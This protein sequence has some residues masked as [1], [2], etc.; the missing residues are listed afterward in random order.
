LISPE[1][2]K[3]AYAGSLATLS[4]YASAHY[5]TYSILNDKNEIIA[6]VISGVEQAPA[7]DHNNA[8]DADNFASCLTKFLDSS[9][10][11]SAKE[12]VASKVNII[13]PDGTVKEAT[14]EPAVGDKLVDEET[15]TVTSVKEVKGETIDECIHRLALETT[16]IP[17]ETDE[18]IREREQEGLQKQD[19]SEAKSTEKD[20]VVSDSG[21]VTRW[22]GMQEDPKTGKYIV[23]ITEREEH[24]FDS[25][26][27]AVDF[28]KRK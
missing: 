1:T 2:E 6:N 18:E 17:T 13:K 15:G 26:D 27:S 14:E 28:L 16:A 22:K 25:S 7:N 20:S 8:E 10:K 11:N 19:V 3:Q 24:V 12:A 23:Y 4:V 21:E 5:K 9:A